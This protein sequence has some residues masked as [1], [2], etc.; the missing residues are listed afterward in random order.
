VA[1][2]SGGSGGMTVIIMTRCESQKN[3]KCTVGDYYDNDHD[4]EDEDEDDSCRCGCGCC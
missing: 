4:D 1:G 3:K 2:A